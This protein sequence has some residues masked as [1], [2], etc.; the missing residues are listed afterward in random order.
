[1]HFCPDPGM[2]PTTYLTALFTKPS[3]STVPVHVDVAVDVL[4]GR[5][6]G[7]A[8]WTWPW[9]CFVDGDLNKAVSALSSP[10]VRWCKRWRQSD[11]CPWRRYAGRRQGAA[12]YGHDNPERWPHPF[13]R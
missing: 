10:G 4:R 12:S 9:T 2:G 7:R 5:G 13:A 1:M 3:T 8:S 6:R 11:D